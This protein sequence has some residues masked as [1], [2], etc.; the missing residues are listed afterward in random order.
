[1]AAIVDLE[2]EVAADGAGVAGLADGADPLAGPDAVAAIDGRRAGQVGVEVAAPLG[3]AVDQQVVAV[4]DRVI[5]GA[6]HAPG[7][8][9]DERRPTG[10]DDVKALMS[11]PAAARDAELAD[12]AAGPVGPSDREDVGEEF[13]PAA[14]T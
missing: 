7:R 1:M 8:R 6:Q 12:V 9:R 3:L 13:R 2:V 4:E 11:A 5:A 10:G 14:P